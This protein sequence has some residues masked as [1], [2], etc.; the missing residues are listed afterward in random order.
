LKCKLPGVRIPLSPP[1]PAEALAKAGPLKK[2]TSFQYRLAS[3]DE[4]RR[5]KL[6]SLCICEGWFFVA[7]YLAQ[8]SLAFIV[9]LLKLLQKQNFFSDLFNH[10][11]FTYI[12]C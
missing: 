7:Y 4:V 9:L 3:A 6:T 10:V 8:N 2:A 11:F 5:K 1:S 12:F